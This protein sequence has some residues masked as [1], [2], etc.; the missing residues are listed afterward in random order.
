MSLIVQMKRLSKSYLLKLDLLLG[1]NALNMYL[2]G[3]VVCFQP[4]SATQMSALLFAEI[5]AEAGLPEG[6]FNVV[7]GNGAFGSK[8]AIHPAID[9]VAFTGSTEV[10]LAS[11]CK[12]LSPV[13]TGLI[14]G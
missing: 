3:T 12:L 4:A 6:V 2:Y 10:R 1:E 8:L 11:M 14:L 7:T 5:C 9:K 13:H